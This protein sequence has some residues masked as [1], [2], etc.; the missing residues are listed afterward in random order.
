MATS[1]TVAFEPSIT[2]CI[3]EAYERCN[4]QL[5]SGYS[6]KTALFSLNILFSEWGNR[7]IHFWAVSNT[8]IYLTSSFTIEALA[9]LLEKI[10]EPYFASKPSF[11]IIGPENPLEL[12]YVD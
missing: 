2:Q 9:E 5:T 3:E 4:V 1:G 11:A 6:L 7:G 12:G 8:N 10:S